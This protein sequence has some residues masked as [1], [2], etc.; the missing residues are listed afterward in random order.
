LR[1]LED[2]MKNPHVKSPS[3][4]PCASFQSLQVRKDFISRTLAHFRFSA[5]PRPTSLPPLSNIACPATSLIGGPTQSVTRPSSFLRSPT[6]R[7]LHLPC[8]ISPLRCHLPSRNGRYYTP[9]HSPLTPVRYLSP[10]NR[11]T[12][13]DHHHHRRPIPSPLGRLHSTRPL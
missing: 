8:A 7:R 2:F 11:M 13:S 9:P 3:K 12:I 5:Q 4:S 10:P 1:S 6:G